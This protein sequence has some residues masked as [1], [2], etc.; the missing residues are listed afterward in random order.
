MKMLGMRLIDDDDKVPPR[1]KGIH[2]PQTDLNDIV[3]HEIDKDGD[4]LSDFDKEF[5]VDGSREND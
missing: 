3:R 1:T 5:I 2:G 4:W